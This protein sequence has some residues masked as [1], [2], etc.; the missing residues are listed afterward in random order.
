L[1]V[2]VLVEQQ[3]V[4]QEMKEAMEVIPSFQVVG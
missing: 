4:L 3:R 2:A 1:A